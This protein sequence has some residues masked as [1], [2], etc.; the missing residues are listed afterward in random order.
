M[1]SVGTR[2]KK[3]LNTTYV[4]NTME[5]TP[6]KMTFTRQITIFT[7][8]CGA[9]W[10]CYTSMPHVSMGWC[11]INWAQG[12]RLLPSVH[13]DKVHA[14]CRL[15]RIRGRFERRVSVAP[16]DVTRRFDTL[17]EY[18]TTSS[19]MALQPLPSSGYYSCF[20]FRR[21]LGSSPSL[22][23]GYPKILLHIRVLPEKKWIQ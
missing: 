4:T 1:I 16:A 5:Q 23:A 19:S 15:W 2:T 9:G 10:N 21:T 17:P 11:S 20:L 8:K 7:T 22:Q 3:G 6:P 14:W 13:D 18:Q 12:Q